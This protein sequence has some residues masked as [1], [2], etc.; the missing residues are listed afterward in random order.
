MRGGLDARR[1]APPASRHACAKHLV[2]RSDKSPS[3]RSRPDHWHTGEG[4]GCRF[5]RARGYPTDAGAWLLPHL[6]QEAEHDR[7]MHVA[8]IV[9]PFGQLAGWQNLGWDLTPVAPEFSG[10]IAFMTDGRAISYAESVMGYV[11]AR[12][13]GTI[14][15]ELTAGTN[16]QG[17]RNH[18]PT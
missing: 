4:P 2:R 5:R 17:D 3:G 14:I 1:D 10:K 16:I 7:W 15:G 9:G 11:A 13:L 6:L 8:K 12:K 18:E